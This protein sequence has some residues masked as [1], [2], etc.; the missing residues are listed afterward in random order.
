[1]CGPA[2]GESASKNSL[3]MVLTG[4]VGLLIYGPSEP[5]IDK[6]PVAPRFSKEKK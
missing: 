4:W 3:K 1:L 5:N 6:E 2:N